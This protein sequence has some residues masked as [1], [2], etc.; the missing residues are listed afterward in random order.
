M[1]LCPMCG[2]DELVAVRIPAI[3]ERGARCPACDSYWRRGVPIRLRFL[4]RMTEVLARHELTRGQVLVDEG[5]WLY[6]AYRDSRSFRQPCPACQEDD[7]EVVL[8]VPTRSRLK[9]CPHCDAC[10]SESVEPSSKDHG[11]VG[12]YL[13]WQGLSEKDLVVASSSPD[14][15]PLGETA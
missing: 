9:V 3:D 5:D 8:V 13:Q 14:G 4:E 2:D 11:L 7:L 10:W 1:L 6:D 15:P 12:V